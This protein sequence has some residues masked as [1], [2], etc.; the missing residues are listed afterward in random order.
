MSVPVSFNHS[1]GYC[2][3]VE[4]KGHKPVGHYGNG[5]KSGSMR[6]G[7]DALVFTK[8]SMTKSVG[9]LSQTFLAEIKAETVLVPIVTWDVQTG[10]YVAQ[11]KYCILKK[12]REVEIFIFLLIII[13]WFQFSI[14]QIN[15]SPVQILAAWTP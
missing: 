3:K 9:F 11:V 12:I 5:F 6:I 10:M 1:F 14:S 8:H 7:K 13:E 4:I 15:C 2:E